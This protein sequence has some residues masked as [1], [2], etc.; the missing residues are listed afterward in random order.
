MEL[1]EIKILGI[2]GSLRKDSF[3]K[4]LL[5]NSLEAVRSAGAAAT[6]I[7]LAD[8]PMPVYDGDFEEQQG[9]PPSAI[10]LKKIFLSHHAL[11]IASPEYNSSISAALKNAIDWV[12]R[13][14]PGEAA[15]AAFQNKIALLMSASPGYYGGM[16]G[17]VH[18]RSILSNIG[19]LVLPQQ[20]V[21]SS[22]D[23]AFD[24]NGNLNDQHKKD[25]LKLLADL[26]VVSSAKLLQDE[27]AAAKK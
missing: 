27:P 1:K 2:A 6:E 15:L 11:L 23:R 4:K 10:E 3:N 25:N 5:K 14:L 18:L 17:L 20:F 16:R 22:A 13:S 9:I 26:L 19:V 24:H 7:D 8:F 21:L 12:S